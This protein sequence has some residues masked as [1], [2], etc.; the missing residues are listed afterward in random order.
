MRGKTRTVTQNTDFFKMQLD[1]SHTDCRAALQIAVFEAFPARSIES[2]GQLQARNCDP[3]GLGN[4]KKPPEVT[5]PREALILW[6]EPFDE[7]SSATKQ[8]AHDFSRQNALI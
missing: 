4:Q 6:S 3:R 2:I 7:S 8:C 5:K 1:D